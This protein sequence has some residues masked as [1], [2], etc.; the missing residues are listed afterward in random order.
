MKINLFRAKQQLPLCSYDTGRCILS[1][2]KY[3]CQTKPDS[4]SGHDPS[5]ICVP[6]I[7]YCQ[8]IYVGFEEKT[9]L[10]T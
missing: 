4:T 2:P 6:N 10:D 9:K 3:F 1:L 7:E 5:L 8:G